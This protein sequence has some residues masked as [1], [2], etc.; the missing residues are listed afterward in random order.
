MTDYC[1]SS[2]PI[3]R[4]IA[5]PNAG[6]SPNVTVR[7]VVEIFQGDATLLTLPIIDEG[8]F[9][10]II[11][12]KVLIFKHLGRPFTMELYG[13]KPIRELLDECPF[14]MNAGVDVNSALERLIE[15]DPRLETD[16]F[17][18][19]DG[20][21]CIGIA[22]V[23][24]LMMSISRT[25]A[26]LLQ[27][28]NRLT[29]RIRAEVDNAR[30]IQQDLLPLDSA[31]FNNIAISASMTTST[32]IGGDFYD[33]IRL[34]DST[35]CIVM[36]DV[37]GHGIQAGMVTTAAK[38]SLHTLIAAGATTPARLLSGMNNAILATARQNLLM[39]CVVISINQQQRIAT[40]ANAGHTFPYLYRTIPTYMERIE[41]VSGFPLGFERDGGYTELTIPFREG[42]RLIVYTDGIVEATDSAGRQF[43]YERFEAVFLEHRELS[44][45]QLKEQL[46]TDIHSFAASEALDDDVALLIASFDGCAP[47]VP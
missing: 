9:L 12:R 36:G 27:T 14:T 21:C 15:V 16:S 26:A 33:Y 1:E 30:S 34:P 44:S 32:E 20:K 19:M 28:L 11:N 22:S 18:V 29:A 45:D 10:G 7:E 40:I 46:F 39:T 24:E 23:A 13:K 43:G 37:S 8:E 41:V 6:V 17:P 25:Q 31:R 3:L 42:D 38:A 47:E 4:D 5:V 35:V 2:V